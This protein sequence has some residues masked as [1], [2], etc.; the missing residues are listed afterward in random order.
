MISIKRKLLPIALIGILLIGIGCIGPFAE[1]EVDDDE[2]NGVPENGV[3]ENETD[4]EVKYSLNVET[5]EG[6]IIEIDPD[7]E[8]Y[9]EGEEVTIT[10]TPDM[11]WEFSEWTGDYEGTEEEITVTMDEDK[12]ITANFEADLDLEEMEE[13]YMEECTLEDEEMEEYCQCTFDYMVDEYGVQVF[14]DAELLDEA[15]ME[16]EDECMHLIPME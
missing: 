13:A 15:V 10:A 4:E 3:P 9:E 1:D 2:E 8:E 6:G 16:A 12:E 14:I 11:E 5:T 7:K